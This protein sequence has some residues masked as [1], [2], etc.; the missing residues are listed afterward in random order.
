MITSPNMSLPIPQASI[1]AGPAWAQEVQNSLTII[2]SHNHA[3]GSGVPINP[4]GLNINADLTMN[5]NDLTSVRSIRFFASTIAATSPDLACIYSQG[6]DLYYNDA[7]GNKIQITSGGG[8]NSGAGSINGLPS[9][10]ASATYLPSPGTFRWQQATST[11]ANLDAATLIIRYPGSYPTI[12]GTGIAI[13]APTA[14]SSSYAITLP[15]A[16]PAATSTV[17]MDTS[18]NIGFQA[19]FAVPTGVIFPYGAASAPTGFLNCDGSAVSRTTYSALFAVISTSYGVGDGSTTFNLPNTAGRFLR[20]AGT[21]G[22]YTTTIG[23]VQAD[24]TKKNGLAL[25]DPTHFHGSNGLGFL[26]NT[27]GGGIIQPGGAFG[28]QANTAAASTGITLGSGDIETRPANVGVN[29][30]IK[31]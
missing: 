20:G 8:V 7:A 12:T 26:S 16:P 24:T 13:Q 5:Q 18:G 30:I 22:V 23:A 19:F 27:G 17:T 21:S 1:D 28:V 14:L 6:V 15:T 9:G 29:Y 10:T 4:A 2:D 3:P 31:T 25:S 11:A